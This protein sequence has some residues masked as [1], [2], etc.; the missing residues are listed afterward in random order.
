MLSH[1]KFRLEKIH[2]FRIKEKNTFIYYAFLLKYLNY[3]SL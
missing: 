2:A 3:E 1:L